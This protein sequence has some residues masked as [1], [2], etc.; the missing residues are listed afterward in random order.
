MT[1]FDSSFDIIIIGGG[2]AGLT[3][4]ARLSENPSVTVAV[5]EAGEDRTADP[6]VSTPGMWARTIKS[7]VDW[8]FRTT[9]Q[10]SPPRKRLGGVCKADLSHPS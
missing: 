2:T 9:K 3:L 7:E 8:D 4:A 10:A 5:L 6:R 1:V